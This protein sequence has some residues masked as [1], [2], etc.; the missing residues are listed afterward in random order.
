MPDNVL[1]VNVIYPSLFITFFT[2]SCAP[3]G[4]QIF[5]TLSLVSHHLL[6]ATHSLSIN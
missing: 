5:I 1:L 4:F 6:S 3:V 2:L